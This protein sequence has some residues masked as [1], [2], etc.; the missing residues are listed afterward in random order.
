PQV[1]RP[2]GR[3]APGSGLAR[4]RQRPLLPRPRR[5]RLA[6]LFLVFSTG[7]A[8]RRYQDPVRG[9]RPKPGPPLRAWRRSVVSGKS[10]SAADGSPCSMADRM[11]VTSLMRPTITSAGVTGQRLGS[12]HRSEAE[13]AGAWAS[14]S[15]SSAVRDQAAVYPAVEALSRRG[16]TACHIIL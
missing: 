6:Y 13:A 4:V 14:V 10:C 7:T 3:P 16:R 5:R 1:R 12:R 11:P 15:D 9:V 2:P 8:L